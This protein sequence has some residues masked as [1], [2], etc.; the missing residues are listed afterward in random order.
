MPSLFI[1]PLS[2][3]SMSFALTP[4]PEEEHNCPQ[5]HGSALVSAF[6]TN[7]DDASAHERLTET[8]IQATLGGEGGTHIRVQVY[9]GKNSWVVF[10]LSADTPDAIYSVS[11]ITLRLDYKP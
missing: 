9:Q 8:I 6:C 2:D 3:P 1:S 7:D 11:G 5:V 4:T 10:T